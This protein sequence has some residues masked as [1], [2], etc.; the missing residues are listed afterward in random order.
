MNTIFCPKCGMIKTK[1]ICSDKDNKHNSLLER[2]SAEEKEELQRQHPDIDDEIIENFPF[3]EARH[4]QLELITEILN[5]FEDGKRYV[6]L[7]AGT[8]TGKSAIAATLGQILQPAYILTMTKQLQRQYADEFGYAQVKGRNNF[9]C[10][11]SGSLNTCDQGTC[12]TIRT[13]DEFTCPYGIK[14]EPNHQKD[15]RKDDSNNYYTT[16]FTFKS[17]EKCPYW[18]QKAISIQ[19]PVTLLNYDYAYLELNYVQHFQKRNLM[20]LDEAHNIEDKIMHKL[21]L[22]IYSR[23]LEKDINE[24]IPREM[25][26]YTDVKDW[27]A[28][29]EAIFDSY[30]TINTT[31][32][33]KQKGDRIDH[34]KRK[35]KEITENIKNDP[36]NWVVSIEDE[37]VSFKPLKINKYAEKTLFQYADKILFMSATILDKDLFCKWLGLDPEEVY[38]IKSESPFKKEYRPIH[39]KLVGPMSKR[40]LWHTA[41]K[42]I[43]VLREILD[44]HKDEKGLI[45]T[46]SY[47]CQ[48]YITEHIRDQRILSHTPKTREQV[49]AEFEKSKNP[50]VLVS[51]SMSEGVDLPYEKCQFQVIYKV[52]YPYL[53]DKQINERKNIDPQWYAYKTIMTLMQAY[54]RGM[55]AEN[56]HCDTYILDKNIQ[57]IL[58]NKMYR[59]L[60]PKFFREAITK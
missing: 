9:S 6:I 57:T 56:D 7:E 49:L 4:N 28:F 10:L 22:N 37:M 26:S 51:P 5:A 58:R 50:Y 18:N 47:K 35:I 13:S 52:P 2:P 45:H 41:P 12:Q 14:M 1:C 25:M 24:T 27:I 11:D 60:I 53:G 19:E 54:G 48:Q 32:L 29:L 55:R 43:P 33:T 46:N 40:A 59:K 44:K 21:E 3:K 42:T 34:T 39:M 15:L 30:N 17:T 38:Y 36:E 31:M 23:Q 8:G 16:P 20:V